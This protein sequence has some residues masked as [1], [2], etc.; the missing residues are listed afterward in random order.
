MIAIVFANSWIML[1]WLATKRELGT[2]AGRLGG[3]SFPHNWILSSPRLVPWLPIRRHIPCWTNNSLRPRMSHCWHS[4]HLP[5][6]RCLW[7]SRRHLM[8]NLWPS[9]PCEG[10]GHGIESFVQGI[11]QSVIWAFQLLLEQL[12]N[13]CPW[14]ASRP[15]WILI[16]KRDSVR[17]LGRWLAIPGF[18]SCPWAPGSG[19]ESIL[20][21]S[22]V[23]GTR[24]LGSWECAF[25]LSHQT[26]SKMDVTL[27]ARNTN[28][29]WL[30]HWLFQWD[31]RFR[32]WDLY[33]LISGI[34]GHN[35]TQCL[36]CTLPKLHPHKATKSYHVRICNIQWDEMTLIWHTN[37]YI[38]M[39]IANLHANT[40]KRRK[41]VIDLDV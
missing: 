20:K 2:G 17:F 13:W 1:W 6:H 24:S 3:N 12:Q 14:P 36:L 38:Y 4:R 39:N 28:Y 41:L 40:P 31:S 32:K 15:C 10:R 34:S 9:E 37:I 22:G 26:A 8:R 30:F 18:S 23:R 33:V 11:S 7:G 5:H 25:C 35:C 16:A 21:R 19:P 27:T 29:K